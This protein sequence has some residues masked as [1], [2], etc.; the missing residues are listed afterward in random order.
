MSAFHG[1]WCID[2]TCSSCW[3]LN[4][5]GE[6]RLSNAEVEICPRLQHINNSC[7]SQA[8]QT[9]CPLS[10]F[11]SMAV[12]WLVPTLFLLRSSLKS[13]IRAN[14]VNSCP[15]SGPRFDGLR[16][17]WNSHGAR[18]VCLYLH[19]C[20]RRGLTRRLLSIPRQRLCSSHGRH[21]FD[22]R[23][24]TNDPYVKDAF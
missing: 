4:G 5:D 10:P 19:V 6:S 7:M 14:I 21:W 1:V 20:I 12:I 2:V 8:P 13:K 17:R 16:L 18:L 9:L 3:L 11:C 23:Q 15:R 22:Q 24:N